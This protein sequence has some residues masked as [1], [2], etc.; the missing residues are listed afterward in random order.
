MTTEP[1][2]AALRRAAETLKNDKKLLLLLCGAA[3][4]AVLLLFP[5]G[6]KREQ[7][8]PEPLQEAS[9]QTLEAELCA[10]L[11]AIEGVG[12]VRV[13]LRAASSGETVFALNT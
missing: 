9:M 7:A 13:M 5:D 10:L 11:S 1:I 3:I 12:D 4:L 2:K 8:Q 6:E